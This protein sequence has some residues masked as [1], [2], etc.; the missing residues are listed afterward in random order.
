MLKDNVLDI[1]G[2][3]AA[4]ADAKSFEGA[5]LRDQ[6]KIGGTRRGL[7]ITD[8]RAEV[9][10]DEE[11]R[12]LEV[13]MGNMA[14]DARGESLSAQLNAYEVRKTVGTLSNRE[15]GIRG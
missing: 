12:T 4:R 7:G 5:I 6:E 11:S 13:S 10:A 8:S 1:S 3:S 15:R 14:A 2:R 9:A